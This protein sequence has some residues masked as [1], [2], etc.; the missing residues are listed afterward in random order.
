MHP[1]PTIKSEALDRSKKA[2]P[3]SAQPVAYLTLL[4]FFVC[5]TYIYKLRTDG[6]FACPAD[7]PSSERYLAYCLTVS[8]GDYDHG[9]FWFG[10]DPEAKQSVTDAEVLFLGNSRLQYAFSNQATVDW[11]ASRAISYYLLGFS[12]NG[13][14]RFSEPLLERLNPKAKV[15]VINVDRFFDSVESDPVAQIFHGTNMRNRYIRKQRWQPVHRSICTRLP[16]ICGNKLAVFRYPETG[17]WV[18]QGDGW[19]FEPVAISD[20]PPDDEDYWA[21]YAALG[22]QFIAKLPVERECVLLTIAPYEETKRAE[23]QAI[24]RALNL[25]FIAPDL[26]GLM[27]FDRSHLDLPSSERW[28][29]AFFNSA[30]MR[31]QLCLDDSK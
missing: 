12:H 21:Q 10:L 28:A 6:I 9:A 29:K 30:G 26:D 13:N 2:G 20:A 5:G 22:K 31:I 8:Y 7:V 17:S 4:I 23:A 24:A 14:A 18:M 11:F 27:T 16:S 15:Y 19:W 25:T 1:K 3:F